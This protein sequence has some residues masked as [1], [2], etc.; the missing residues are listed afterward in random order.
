MFA[1]LVTVPTFVLILSSLASA[2]AIGGNTG[3]NAGAIHCCNK[4]FDSGLYTRQLLDLQCV[5][6]A[7]A[8]GAGVSCHTQTACCQDVQESSIL[9]LKCEPFSLL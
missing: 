6:I 4:V 5:P 1:R 7:V 2:V 9:G 8:G 3:C